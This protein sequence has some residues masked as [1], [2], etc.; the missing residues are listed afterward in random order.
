MIFLSDQLH[1]WNK[2]TQAYKYSTFF[3]QSEEKAGTSLTKNNLQ[4]YETGG[5]ASQEVVKIDKNISKK[6][7]IDQQMIKKV[8]N[9]GEYY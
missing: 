5:Q 7:P 2:L 3:F 9:G 4:D 8:K 6:R 1:S